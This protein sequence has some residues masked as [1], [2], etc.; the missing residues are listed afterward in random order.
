MCC[1]DVL[2]MQ[3]QSADSAVDYTADY[4][5][6]EATAFT[7]VSSEFRVHSRAQGSQLLIIFSYSR[8]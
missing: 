1:W 5:S 8:L 3:D 7:Q 2:V 4:L 6:S